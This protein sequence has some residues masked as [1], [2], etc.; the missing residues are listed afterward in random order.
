MPFFTAFDIARGAPT[1]ASTC[2]DTH[3]VA[4][5]LTYIVTRDQAAHASERGAGKGKKLCI[6]TSRESSVVRAFSFFVS[7]SW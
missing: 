6:K 7:P 5:R 1:R 2:A 4:S 3:R